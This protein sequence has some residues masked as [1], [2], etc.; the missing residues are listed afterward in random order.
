MGY[1]TVY[2]LSTL[3]GIMAGKRDGRFEEDVP[4]YLRVVPVATWAMVEYSTVQLRTILR[5]FDPSKSSK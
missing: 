4:L 1:S 5:M 3:I 2:A